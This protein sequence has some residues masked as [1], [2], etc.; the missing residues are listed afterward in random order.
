METNQIFISKE[1]SEYI[2]NFRKDE[3]CV[4]NEMRTIADAMCG[5]EITLSGMFVD[6]NTEDLLKQAMSAISSYHWLL[7]LIEKEK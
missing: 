1:L 7:S 2:N 5:L 6:E 3:R 4:L